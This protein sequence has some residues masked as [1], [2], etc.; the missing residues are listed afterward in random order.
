MG[1]VRE[2]HPHARRVSR[3]LVR[4]YGD[5]NLGNK[6][7]PFNELLYVLLSSKTPPGRYQATYIAL[8]R[9]FP[10]ADQ[11]AKASTKSIVEAIQ[12]G[13]LGA[14]K[15]GQ[16]KEIAQLLRK[17]FGRVTLTPLRTAST[18]DIEDFLTKLPGVGIKVSRCIELFAFGRDVF[19][20]DAHCLRIGTRLEWC[21]PS[22]TKRVVNRLQ[23]GIPCG[24]RRRMHVG[25]VLLGREFC[26]PSAPR[27]CNCPIVEF[28]PTGRNRLR[29]DN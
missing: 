14:K 3:A 19:P 2:Y 24:L 27:C 8:R 16:I 29:R 25:F 6:K 5:T 17:C 15:A 23:E 12:V 22:L 7:N 21:T 26:R 18:G 20:V 13:G 10:K 4:R 1:R 9:V 28:C 11:L